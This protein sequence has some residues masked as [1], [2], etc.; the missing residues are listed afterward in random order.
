VWRHNT[1][2]DYDTLRAEYPH[3]QG[4]LSEGGHLALECRA[5]VVLSVEVTV[6]E[7]GW[8]AAAGAAAVAATLEL[9]R[10]VRE[11]CCGEGGIKFQVDVLWQ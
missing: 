9:K 7:L 10:L 2:D 6:P 11:K 1:E 5:G 8:A 4:H 3:T